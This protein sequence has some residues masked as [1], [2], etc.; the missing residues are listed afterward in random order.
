[1]Q[2]SFSDS[3]NRFKKMK[4]KAPKKSKDW[5][6]EKKERRRRQGKYVQL[7]PLLI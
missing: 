6:Q 3:R 4:G 7:F 1:M 2:A 5:I